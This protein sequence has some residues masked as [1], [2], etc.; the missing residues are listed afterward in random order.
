MVTSEK[1]TTFLQRTKVRL[2]RGGDGGEGTR[3]GCLGK[4]GHRKTVKSYKII[5]KAQDTLW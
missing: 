3:E 4:Y 2:C 1:R 5:T